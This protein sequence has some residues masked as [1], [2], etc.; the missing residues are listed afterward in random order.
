MKDLQNWQKILFLC[1]KY[2]SVL[3]LIFYFKGKIFFFQLYSTLNSDH[4]LWDEHLP[5]FRYTINTA[6]Q[7]STKTSPAFLNF[8]RELKLP[9]TIERKENTNVTLERMSVEQ[10]KNHVSRLHALRVLVSKFQFEPCEIQAKYHNATETAGQIYC[11]RL[12][13]EKKENTFVSCKF[14]S[15]KISQEI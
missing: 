2:V 1:L 9:N 3:Q 10:W 4:S 5:K 12:S 7:V 15:D 13:L 8:G 6:E 11:C 14:C